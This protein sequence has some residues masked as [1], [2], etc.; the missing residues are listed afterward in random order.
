MEKL[1]GFADCEGGDFMEVIKTGDSGTWTG[2]IEAI[3]SQWWGQR[4]T[5]AKEG[6]WLPG[7]QIKSKACS[8]GIYQIE[9][10]KSIYIKNN[11]FCKK[12]YTKCS[13][14]FS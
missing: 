10:Y 7:D 3:C 1:F 11:S 13:T 9:Y 6:D 12:R 8:L 14:I 2:N 4:T 5:D